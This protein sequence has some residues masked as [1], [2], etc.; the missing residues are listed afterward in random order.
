MRFTFLRHALQTFLTVA[1][2]AALAACS[3]SIQEP[4]QNATVTLPSPTSTTKVIVTGNA[5]YTGLKVT[6]DGVDFSNQMVSKAS[7]RDEGNLSLQQTTQAL[8]GVPGTHTLVASAEV[9]CWYCTGSKTQSTD[10][11]TFLVV[12]PEGGLPSCLKNIGAP[13][14]PD[15]EVISSNDALQKLFSI[16]LANPTKQTSVWAVATPSQKDKWRMTIEEFVQPLQSNEALV[17]L[18]NEVKSG[19]EKEMLTVNG[20]N[21]F[22]AGQL[23]HVMGGAVSADIK[24][25][26]ADTTT[27]LF[28]KPVFTPFIT[29]QNV[30][31]WSE[32]AFWALFGGKKITF[33]WKDD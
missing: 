18:G 17:V 9:Y 24:I 25:T 10:W 33:T 7:D 32:P 2:A 30:A 1:A 3:I 6:G 16:K 20:N 11:H 19:W 22:I 4:A 13:P 27:L 8:P 14:P 15:P 28:R 5:T 31:V 23:A 26:K 21:C 29:W 12:P